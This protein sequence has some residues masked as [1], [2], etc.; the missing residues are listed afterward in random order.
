M[1]G[2]CMLRVIAGLKIAFFVVLLHSAI[3]EAEQEE[4]G[5]LPE[6]Q[7]V[8]DELRGESNSWYDVTHTYLAISFCRPAVWFDN[9]FADVRTDEEFRA[10]TRVRWQNDFVNTEGRGFDFVTKFSASFKLPKAKKRINLFFEGEEQNA[11][12]D[13]V[14]ETEREARG[15]LGLLYEVKET[16]RGNLSLRIKLS[17]SITLRYRYRYPL[18]ETFISRFTLELYN[19]DGD[20]GAT[21]R[22]D[23][24]KRLSS[25]FFLRQ[26]N[27]VTTAESLEGN[28]WGAGLVLYHHLS[29]VS[30]LSYES[31][32]SGKTRPDDYV[33]NTRIGIRYR[34]NFYRKWLF[35]E[36][37]PAVTWPRSLITDERNQAWEFLF[38]LEVNFVNL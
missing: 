29:D 9:F 24:E 7:N 8:C 16:A 33:S 30:A 1:P 32:V 31:G 28:E 19:K 4:S 26:S 20:E 36:I 10:G 5:Q 2:M 38:R 11:L 18:S 27:T 35:Y 23:F 37:A 15:A 12:Q 3:A 17:P 34:R 6:K 22:L 21:T 13:V 14:P 25:D